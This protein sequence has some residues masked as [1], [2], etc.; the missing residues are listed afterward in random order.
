MMHRSFRRLILLGSLFSAMGI[1]V[2]ATEAEAEDAELNAL[3]ASAD[4][5][6][7]RTAAVRGS[8]GWRDNILLSTYAPLGRGF[9]R[10]ELEAFL[11]RPGEGRWEFV[12]FL[13]GNVLR[14]FSPPPETGG[15]Q[16]WVGHLEARFRAMENLRLSL[17]GDA[18]FQDLVVDLS[19]TEATRVVAPTRAA[20]AFATFLAHAT[21]PLGLSLEPLLQAKRSDYR[22][23]PGDYD[24]FKGGARLE[25]KR[26]DLLAISTA[27]YEHHRR[28]LQRS[29]YTAGGRA[30]AGTHL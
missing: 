10:G 19:E 2:R 9:V 8:L 25:W 27:F 21:V 7:I 22:D 6:W 29:A 4:A 26:R 3:L 17:K 24:E 20:G 28:Y 13:N 1:A 23:Y 5:T 30:L 11:W 15:E 18:Y 14:Y 12:S 16:Q